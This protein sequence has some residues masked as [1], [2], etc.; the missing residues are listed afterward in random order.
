MNFNKELD[1]LK[2]Y[3]HHQIDGMFE[4]DYSQAIYMI[5]LNQYEIPIKTTFTSFYEWKI[6]QGYVNLD[7]ERSL[8]AK[9]YLDT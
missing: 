4:K 8:T 5:Y 6:K 1:I 2:E 3:M 9:R 7:L